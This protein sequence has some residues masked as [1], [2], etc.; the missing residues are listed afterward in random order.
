MSGVSYPLAMPEGRDS[1]PVGSQQA[2]AA[3]IQ[4]HGFGL[5]GGCS[6][7][8][9]GVT[10]ANWA[11]PRPP[12]GGPG[13]APGAETLGSTRESSREGC[14]PNPCRRLEGARPRA[15]LAAGVCDL[16]LRVHLTQVATRASWSQATRYARNH[17]LIGEASLVTQRSMAAYS[18]SPSQPRFRENQRA[19]LDCSRQDLTEDRTRTCRR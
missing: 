5:Q 14:H 9:R 19:G 13:H 2:P 4:T 18:P 16:S 11:G 10:L 8:P 3:P 7:H 12:A 15:I 1:S 17:S 6:R